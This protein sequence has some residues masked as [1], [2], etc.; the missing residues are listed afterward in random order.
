MTNVTAALAVNPA[1]AGPSI[2][3]LGTALPP[4]RYDQKELLDA[5]RR[6]W[7]EHHFN[8]DRLVRLHESVQVGGRALA[9]PIEA[10]EELRGFGSANDAF[11]AVASELSET[12]LRQAISRAGV[13]PEDID[14]IFFTTVTGIATPSIDAHLVNRLS[15]RRD[16]KRVP[17]FGLGCV[18][19]AAGLARVADYLRGHPDDVAVLVSAELCSLT[20]QRGDLSIPNFIATGLFGDG[21]AA[22]VAVGARRANASRRRVRVVATQSVLYPDTQ[23]IMGWDVKDTGL[24]VV[25]SSVLSDFIRDHVADDVRAFVRA[26]GY[27]LADIDHWICHPGGPKVLAA[28]EESLGLGTRALRRSRELLEEVGNLSSASVLFV[29]DRTWPDAGP[30]DLGL[31]LAM[32]PG[33]C[34]ELVLLSWC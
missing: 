7:Q 10:Y 28:L 4:N 25:L 21:C 27:E 5:L 18:G 32:G 23:W 17:M 20:L 9:L 26:Q 30:G 15:L 3:G 14:A 19:G 29:L 16:V 6:I 34:A 24:K 8:E 1:Y 31:L 13:A 2:E 22:L 33:F 12:S 11:V